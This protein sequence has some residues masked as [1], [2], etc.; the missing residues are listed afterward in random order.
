VDSWASE[1]SGE[2]L[3]A[4]YAYGHTNT[5]VD[6]SNVPDE[7]VTTFSLDDPSVL[8][9]PNSHPERPIDRRDVYEELWLEV[10]ASA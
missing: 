8:E 10:K 7:L 6:L 9:E 2:W 5:A 1:A 4:N 3:I